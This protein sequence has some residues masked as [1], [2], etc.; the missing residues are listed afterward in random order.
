M[1]SK[2]TIETG[3][4]VFDGL[5]QYRNI[6]TARKVVAAT[7]GDGWNEKYTLE[8]VDYVPQHLLKI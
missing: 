6:G 4:G 1:A 3:I 2:K 7:V 8:L 5:E